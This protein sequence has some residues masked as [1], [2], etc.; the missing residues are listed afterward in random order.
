MGLLWILLL[1]LGLRLY[2]LGHTY[3]ISRDAIR[4]IRMGGDLA[5][6]EIRKGLDD[7]YPPGYPAFIALTALVTRDAELAGK[8][9]SV[10]AG[11]LALLPAYGM[12]NRRFGKKAAE[13]A[14]LFLALHPH[15]CRFSAEAQSES[16]YIL[17]L[18]AAAYHGL[19]LVSGAKRIHALPACLFG[20]LA[21]LTRP[22]GLGILLLPALLLLFARKPGELRFRERAARSAM[23]LA[24]FLILSLPFFYYIKG[25]SDAITGNAQ[26][27]AWKLSR[28]KDLSRLLG[29]GWVI[30]REPAGS[31]GK[32][33]LVFH[34]GNFRQ[35]CTRFAL[36]LL[37]NL[38][39]YLEMVHPLLV[40]FLA[41][42]IWEARSP[43]ERRALLTYLMTALVLYLCV[44]SL[45]RADKRLCAQVA[46]LTLPLT[47][48]GV[49]AL[50]KALLR[51]RRKG[52]PANGV[53]KRIGRIAFVSVGIAA[54]V[55]LPMTLK[56]RRLDK[57]A[58]R[59]A[60]LW[61]R[62]HSP[63]GAKIVSDFPRVAYYASRTYLAIPRRGVAL[64]E[65]Y[66]RARAYVE[67]EGAEFLVLEAANV[68]TAL[69][70]RA[71]LSDFIPAMRFGP[72]PG[73][74]GK[75][76]VV[77]RRKA[78]PSPDRSK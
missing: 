77:L 32:E 75:H 70:A 16:I 19:E 30:A 54:A 51:L 29:Y 26:V 41:F 33:K 44:F 50:S 10:L 31:D 59:E 52:T 72:P 74:E 73:V 60:G 78:P 3:I 61:I 14:A 53:Q 76:L 4:Y 55:M 69:L 57:L 2:L 47:G 68:D 5:A 25:Q 49:I 39:Y 43:P 36:R 66:R 56:S 64:E 28:K 24:P 17:F 58:Y 15:L 6:G 34:A 11:V 7:H 42:G 13:F 63:L 71:G 20:L 67:T 23:L 45:V 40:L 46:A 9:V 48:P 65:K 8:V 18:L 37:K 22:E 27:G 21:F 35:F 1:A 12:V 62:E 38:A